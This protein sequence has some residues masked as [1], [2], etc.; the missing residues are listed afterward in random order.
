MR[1]FVLYTLNDNYISE[2][3]LKGKSYEHIENRIHHYSDGILSTNKWTLITSNIEVGYL[4][5][6]SLSE[7]PHLTK[8]DFAMI[9]ENNSLSSS[10]ILNILP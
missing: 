6:I 7:F 9:N 2:R 10:E 3:Y 8:K 4:R 1:Y 5:E